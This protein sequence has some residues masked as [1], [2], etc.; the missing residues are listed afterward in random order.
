VT[1]KRILWIF[2]D[3]FSVPF[4]KI[5]N[6]HPYVPYKG[7]CPKIFSNILSEELD[8]N[9]VD[10]SMGGCSNQSIFHTYIKNVSNIKPNDILIFGWTQ[11]IRFRIA[12]KRNDFY[13]V[14][15]AVAPYMEEF[16]DMSIDT[17]NDITINRSTHSIFWDELIDYINIINKSSNKSLIF[18]WTWVEPTKQF[19]TNVYESKFYDL[20]IPFKKYKTVKE[21]TNGDVDD[22]HYGEVGHIEL[23]NDLLDKIKKML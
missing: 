18:N 14:I 2:G 1:D 22:F 13:D 21:E 4:K 20:L 17:L 23:A 10:M 16:I 8:L 5:E 11:P 19:D 9:L 6:E 3:S 12:S 15:I 7:Y